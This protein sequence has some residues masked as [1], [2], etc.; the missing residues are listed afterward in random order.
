MN[1]TPETLSMLDN[2]LTKNNIVKVSYNGEIYLV[3]SN[4]VVIRKKDNSI[5]NISEGN[6]LY[7]ALQEQASEYF[8]SRDM[9]LDDNT[10]AVP[11]QKWDRYAP[12]SQESYEVSSKG[13]KRFSAFY[14]VFKPN[15]IIDGTNVGGKSIEWVYQNII[16]K[17]GKGKAPSRDS[18]LYNPNLKTDKER[19]DFSYTEGYLPLWKEWARQNPELIEELR[20]KAKGKYLT[21]RFALTRVSQARA[22]ADI[23]NDSNKKTLKTEDN[24]YQRLSQEE[25]GSSDGNLQEAETLLTRAGRADD[26]G[27]EAAKREM[28]EKVSSREAEERIIESWAKE[29]GLWHENIDTELQ[30]K[31]GDKIGHGSES[32]VYLKDDKTVIKSRSV[33][34][35]NSVQEA[36]ESV[37]LH[38]Y[39]NPNTTYK[40]VGVG[41]SDGEFTLMLEQ[42]LIEGR[43]ATQEEIDNYVKSLGFEKG[44]G[45]TNFSN[46]RYRYEDLKPANVLIDA[47]GNFNVID[48]DIYAI[49]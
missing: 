36:I 7:D 15:T 19:E 12:S 46:D 39:L 25:L 28:D 23:I 42:P 35:F 32:W 26:K 10:E 44:K 43:E 13:D 40:L 22:L 5:L 45:K 14:A 17:S 24:V 29:K 33:T 16:K 20:Q 27:P 1:L 49:N 9:E 2:A 38:N 37:I 8:G 31:Y 47:D 6:E 41:M 48:S 18:K 34:L 30:D 3:T 21:D 4:G 11:S